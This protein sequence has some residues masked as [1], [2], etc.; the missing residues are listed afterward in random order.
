MEGWVATM[1]VPSHVSNMSEAQI[2]YTESG[3][4][5]L[6]QSSPSQDKE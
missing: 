6:Q 2:H 1:D 5:E 4:S 3:T